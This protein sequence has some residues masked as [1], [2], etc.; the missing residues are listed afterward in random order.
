MEPLALDQRDVLLEAAE[1][2][3]GRVGDIPM[4]H[5]RTGLAY[6][7]KTDAS[8]VTR[9]DRETEARLRDIIATRFPDHGIVGEEYGSANTDRDIIW[10]IDPID[11]TKSFISGVPLFGVL[12]AALHRGRV[13]AGAIHM[14]G[15]GETFSG[16]AGLGCR[17]N[18]RPVHCRKGVALA[19]A[20]LCGN[21]LG[22]LIR[23]QP[24]VAERLVRTGRF[25]RPTVDCYPYAQLAAGWVDGVIDHGLFPYDY[26]AAVGVV[27]GAGG[28]ITDW[29]GAPLT[30]E[31]DGRVVAAA[32]AEIHDGLL[33]VLR[34]G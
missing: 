14:P 22:T 3:A 33:A 31:S 9:A 30:L 17:F 10:V 26:M 11:G 16:G 23:D 13:V 19:D 28:I 29:T 12:V 5:F 27:E 8:P 6:D 20:F 1:D 7:S 24:D 34:G 4:R 2:I 32:T 18:G 25:L 15:L 21:D